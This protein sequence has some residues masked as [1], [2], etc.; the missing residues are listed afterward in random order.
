MTRNIARIVMPALESDEAAT[1]DA[2]ACL[3]STSGHKWPQVGSSYPFLHFDYKHIKE[4]WERHE[5]DIKIK[6]RDVGRAFEREGLAGD[7]DRLHRGNG[8]PHHGTM[9]VLGNPRP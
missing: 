8:R 4:A 5:R 9:C 7:D 6:C 3:K 1:S 2:W